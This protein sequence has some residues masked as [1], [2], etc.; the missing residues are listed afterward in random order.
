VSEPGGVP[1]EL[2]LRTLL[3]IESIVRSE[4]LSVDSRFHAIRETVER[5]VGG[6]GPA[7][8]L[9]AIDFADK[10]TFGLVTDE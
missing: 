2:L 6:D 10:V 7:G 3:A 8:Y 4:H 9:D 5:A 1:E